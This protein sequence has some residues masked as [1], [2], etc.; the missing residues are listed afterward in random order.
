MLGY[1]EKMRDIAGRLLKECDVEMVIGFRK[2]TMPMMNEPCFV[3]NP[4]MCSHWCGT[5]I[6]ASTWPTT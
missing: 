5:A 1:T 4:K 6:A 2:G 3:T